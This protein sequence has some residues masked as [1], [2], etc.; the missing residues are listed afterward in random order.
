MIGLHSAASAI[1][2]FWFLSGIEVQL[3]YY[4]CSLSLLL[5]KEAQVV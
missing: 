4:G 3:K 5:G 1:K 2:C